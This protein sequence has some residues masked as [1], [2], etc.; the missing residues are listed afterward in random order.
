LR[1]KTQSLSGAQEGN[2]NRLPE[3]AAELVRLKV[4]LI[5]VSGGDPEI[6]T[7]KDVTTD[8]VIK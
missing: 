4:D 8:K 5:V 3:L 2:F 1:G 7:A 6:R